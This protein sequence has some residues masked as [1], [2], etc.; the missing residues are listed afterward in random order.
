[1]TADGLCRLDELE[2][3]GGRSFELE[4]NLLRDLAVLLPATAALLVLSVLAVVRN[5]FAALVPLAGWLARRMSRSTA[6]MT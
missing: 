3:G 4:R 2:D 6:C 5:L 1:M